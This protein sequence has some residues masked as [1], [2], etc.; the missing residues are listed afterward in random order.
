[1]KPNQQISTGT[2]RSRGEILSSAFF[3]LAIL[4]FTIGFNFRDNPPSGWY[5]QFMPD[6]GNQSISSITFID[7]LT[8]FAVTQST[9]ISDTAYVL[10]T[11]N[12]GNNFTSPQSL[13]EG[14]LCASE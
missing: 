1:M 2:R 11:T 5:Q 7:S 9:S 4:I 14:G 6:L 12:G 10:K 8:G 13:S 3:Y